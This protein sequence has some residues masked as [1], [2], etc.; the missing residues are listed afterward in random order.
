M[1]MSQ[2][3]NNQPAG[4]GGMP[5]NNPDA[6]IG[7]LGAV[8]RDNGVLDDVRVSPSDFYRPEHGT[9]WHAMLELSGAG[10]PIDLVTVLDQLARMGTPIDATYLC[11][12]A[13][14]CPIASRAGDY[15]AMVSECSTRRRLI[16]KAQEMGTA[17]RNMTQPL[18]VSVKL[19]QEAADESLDPRLDEG[20]QRPEQICARF[21]SYLDRI[22]EQGGGGIATQ[23]RKLDLLTGGLFPGEVNI[24][25]ARPGCGKTAIAL[26]LGMYA[27]VT[28]NP[29]GMISLEMPGY[30][31]MARLSA[32]SCS[33]DAQRFRTGKFV[34][35]ELARI[36]AFNAKMEKLPF[37]MYDQ[38]S[39]TPTGIRSQARRWKREIGLKFLIIDYLQLIRPDARGGSRE[40]EV[41]EASRTIKELALELDV[42]VLLLAQLNRDAEKTKKPMLSQLRESGAVEQ[43][44]DIVLF[45]SGMQATEA[46]DVVDVDL[47]VAKGRSNACGT[48]PLQ[49][50]RRFLRFENIPDGGFS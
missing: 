20:G 27:L 12:L 46:R 42:P 41:A 38:P 11:Q 29:T 39:I 9:V 10:R 36:K 45:L 17:A 18:D 37:R 25:A 23:F 34:G 43:D 16:A 30:Q 4:Q 33:V 2:P 35:D 26:N 5:P 49:F 24:L 47:D 1:P 50:L 48:V 40:Q 3:T 28:G 14:S 15:G 44:A 22:Q 31:L 6:E 7:L 21:D 8:F 19:A 32:A 13:E